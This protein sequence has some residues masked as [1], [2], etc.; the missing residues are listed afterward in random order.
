MKMEGP[1]AIYPPLHAPL[2]AF[3]GIE[4]FPEGPRAPLSGAEGAG[5]SMKS[6]VDGLD[7]PVREPSRGQRLFSFQQGK[8]TDASHCVIGTVRCERRE[9]LL[10]APRAPTRRGRGL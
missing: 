5:P 6:N 7:A 2:R 9:A 3:L 8:D 4:A 1:R 10:P